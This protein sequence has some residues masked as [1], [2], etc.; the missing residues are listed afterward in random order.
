MLKPRWRKVLRDLWLNRIRTIVVV[1]SIAVGV[2]VVGVISTSQIVLSEQLNEAYLAT[3]PT[4]AFILTFDSFDKD[5]VEAV[6][7]TL[8]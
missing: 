6:T 2:F 5:V 1:F 7:L 3:N 4:S 8:S